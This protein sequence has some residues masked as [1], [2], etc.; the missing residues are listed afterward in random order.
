MQHSGLLSIAIAWVG[1]L[2]MIRHWKGN[3]SMTFSQHAAQ[4]RSSQIYYFL[5][6]LLCLPIFYWFLLHY[7]IP[8][9]GFGF[10]FKLYAAGA[11]TGWTMAAI[12]PETVGWKVRVHRISAFA[13]CYFMA[14]ITVSITTSVVMPV[15]SRTVAA[16]ALL[17]M[18]GEIVYLNMHKRRHP[19]MLAYQLVYFVVFH[20]MILFAWYTR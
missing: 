11:M 8:A 2:Y 15:R 18:L 19:H 6:W 5:L 1:L 3:A 9:F 13:L 7:F 4:K 14:L 10:W 20:V 12:V 16:V 17:V